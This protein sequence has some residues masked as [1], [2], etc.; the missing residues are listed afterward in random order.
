LFRSCVKNNDQP[1]ALILTFS[2][3]SQRAE[4]SLL[5]GCINAF[6]ASKTPPVFYAG[7]RQAC[8]P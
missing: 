3:Y 7:P 1:A 5:K 2:R 6:T 8:P 4:G